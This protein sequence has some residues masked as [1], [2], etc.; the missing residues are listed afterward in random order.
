[1]TDLYAAKGR[2]VDGGRSSRTAGTN[3]AADDLCGNPWLMLA[4]LPVAHVM[5]IP[6][7]AVFCRVRVEGVGPIFRGGPLRELRCCFGDIARRSL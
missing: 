1:M 5:C 2:G 6:V 3:S 7:S 4:R